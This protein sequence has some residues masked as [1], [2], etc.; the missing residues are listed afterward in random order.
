MADT[1]SLINETREF[2]L[3][4]M[5]FDQKHHPTDAE[6]TALWTKIYAASSTS[7]A[8]K[9][10]GAVSG[11]FAGL[12]VNGNLT[13]SGYKAESFALKNHVHEH[14]MQ[15]NENV[16]YD[17]S[18]DKTFTFRVSNG[19]PFV[20]DNTSG[21]TL[22]VIEHLNADLLDGKHAS[23]FALTANLDARYMRLD[24]SNNYNAAVNTLTFSVTSGA[25]F[26]VT[27]QGTA[28]IAVVDN[29]N[30]DLL[31]GKHASAFALEKHVHINYA[32]KSAA[33]DITG[34]WTFNPSTGTAPFALNSAMTSVVTYL[35]ADKLDG[36]DA[37]AFAAAV[38]NHDTA[39]YTKAQMDTALAGKIAIPDTGAADGEI[40]LWNDASQ[41][42]R[43]SG[44]DL[45]DL[46]TQTDIGNK[47]TKVSATTNNLVK[48]ATSG[49]A[50]ADAGVDA[51]DFALVSDIYTQ[52]QLTN[53][54]T[55]LALSSGSTI[56]GAG[57][58]IMGSDEDTGAGV[59]PNGTIKGYINGH[60]Y[61]FL[62]SATA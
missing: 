52:T 59:T 14:Y 4:K 3:I 5:M 42:F 45:S 55:A 2:L 40:L 8:D 61:Y 60:T 41:I 50:L 30:A 22:P 26:V 43:N 29:F 6:L 56:S 38:H 36:N 12:D 10:T 27:K 25:P 23:E 17:A 9:V 58:F 20:I 18:T 62:T 44:V 53:Y 47:Y 16:V 28:I 11:H 13:D 46:A 19:S 39:Y 35:N 33:Q 37:A 48:F 15:D 57:I 34:L 54:T 24:A 51:A 32:D 31:D 21:D 7:K 1:Y 49:T